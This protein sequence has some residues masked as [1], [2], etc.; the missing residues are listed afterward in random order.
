MSFFLRVFLVAI[1][2]TVWY[3]DVSAQGTTMDIFG[4]V[5]DSETQ[6]PLAKASI[7]MDRT[8]RGTTSADDG[9]FALRN[10]PTGNYR[11]VVSFVGYNPV[12]V[13]VNEQGNQQLT[14]QLHRNQKLLNEVV[15]KPNSNWEEY[16]GLFKLFFLGDGGLQCTIKNPKAL[17]LDYD[18]KTYV[19]TA[20]A[21][22]PIVIE[23]QA[24]GYRVYYDLT[25]FAH[26][27]GRTSYSGFSRFEEM[28][29]ADGKQEKKWKANRANAYYGSSV[30]FMQ[31]LVKEQLKEEGFIVK[32]LEK[33]ET[34]PSANHPV[35]NGWKNNPFKAPDTLVSLRWN[36][37]DYAPE[38]T[39]VL[40]NTPK[41]WGS[42][43]GFNV[44]Y[45]QEV[46]YDSVL[47]TTFVVGK[48]NLAFKNS[49]FITY[50]H[51]K[52]TNA[53]PNYGDAGQ[54]VFPISILTMLK[55]KTPIDMHGNLADPNAVIHEGYWSSL[56]VADQL[57]DDYK[58]DK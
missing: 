34:P 17:L 48:Y 9:R 44:L 25:G 5:I 47:A 55:P 58:P 26:H 54:A 3:A 52:I 31:S 24:L 22:E 7:Y 57:P 49:L 46:P 11:L 45:P 51:K 53:A 37:I 10:I 21:K 12:S 20:V 41:D 27:P 56:R 40:D 16:F 38:D 4:T 19:L 30:H 28:Q 18:R 36:G 35:L 8:T 33:T 39:T 15:I 29:P 1:F 32:R 2:S 14:V 6:K 50:L 13:T 43:A 23:N 42:K